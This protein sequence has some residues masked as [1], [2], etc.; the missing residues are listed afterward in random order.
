MTNKL[1][2]TVDIMDGDKFHKTVK[3]NSTVTKSFTVE[4][5]GKTRRIIRVATTGLKLDRSGERLAQS[6]IDK[7]VKA[8]NTGAIPA[9]SNHG[10]NRQHGFRT[11]E[12]QD[13][14][15]KWVAAE[16]AGDTVY[17]DLQLNG[18]NPDADKLWRYVHEENMPVGFSIGGIVVQ[19]REVEIDG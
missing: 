16:Q 19:K 9:F 5:D 13:I 2:L 15:G 4:K 8:H 12:W 14:I 10:V 11:Y 6:A 17:S 7:I 1:G 18:A 3:L